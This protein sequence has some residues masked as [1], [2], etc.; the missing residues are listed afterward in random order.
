[1]RNGLA[2]LTK[3][4]MESKTQAP[5]G[6]LWLIAEFGLLRAIFK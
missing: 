1:M 4:A 3:G 5:E 6:Y 2:I